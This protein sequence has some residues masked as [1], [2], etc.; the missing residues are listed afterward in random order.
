MLVPADNVVVF[1][2]L[3]YVKT[4]KQE[5]DGTRAYQE[6]MYWLLKLHKR[7]YKARCIAKSSIYTTNGLSKLLTSCLTAIKSNV[8]RYCETAYETSNKTWFW[9]MKN[10]ARCSV[11]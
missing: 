3:H 7:P 5:F 2:R 1:C 9:S 11:N 6:T 10:L 8:I 4:F